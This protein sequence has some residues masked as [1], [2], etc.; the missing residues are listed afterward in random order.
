V[1]YHPSVSRPGPGVATRG[2]GRAPP[3]G[4]DR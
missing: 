1:R 3:S 4:G 2:S